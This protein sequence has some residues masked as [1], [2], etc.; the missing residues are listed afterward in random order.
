MSMSVSIGKDLLE[1]ALRKALSEEYRSS[2]RFKQSVEMVISITGIDLSKPAQRFVEL[3][4]LPHNPHKDPPKIC[5]FTDGSLVTEAK[6][7]G[8]DTLARDSLN[9]MAGRKK[10]CR[11]ISQSYDFF[12]SEAPLMPLV[13]RVLGQFLG[14]KNKMPIPVS[15]ASQI[16]P[17]VER[18]GRSV[19][20]VLKSS[21]AVSCKIG[22]EEM[23]IQQLLENANAVISTVERKLPHFAVTRFIGFKTTMGKIVKASKVTKG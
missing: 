6:N 8:L 5:V 2:K 16:S 3:V 22:H 11:K 9:A 1:G 20:L 23:P 13:G 7:L 12:L 10:N 19:R 17:I 4:E 15:P 14:P 18:L 21:S